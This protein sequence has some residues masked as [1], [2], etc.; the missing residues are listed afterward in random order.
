M[1]AE[2]RATREV[3]R[4]A[5]ALALAVAVVGCGTLS[6][7]P[8][9][10][11]PSE[12]AALSYAQSLFAAVASR[13]ADAIC[14]LGT[15]TCKKTLSQA[16]PALLPRT[17]PRVIGTRL[18]EPSQRSDGSWEYGGRLIALCGDDGLKQPYYSE[19]LVF[20]SGQSLI[21]TNPVYWQ[22]ATVPTSGDVTASQ[23]P[24]TCS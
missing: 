21:S 6:P 15:S 14:A 19:L 18:I 1:D 16:D 5:L 9:P 17:S 4:A 2:R 20:Y 7:A 3:R 8:A 24:F 10:T 12:A 22:G 13:N 11:P 23:S